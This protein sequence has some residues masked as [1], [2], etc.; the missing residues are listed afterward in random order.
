M[1]VGVLL[2]LVMVF[3]CQEAQDSDSAVSNVIIVVL[4][5]ARKH[6]ETETE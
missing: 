5:S 4:S 1:H 2:L 3:T 6:T